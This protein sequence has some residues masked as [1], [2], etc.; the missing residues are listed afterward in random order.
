M[1]LP[2]IIFLTI[3]LALTIGLIYLTF[4]SVQKGPLKIIFTIIILILSLVLATVG[5]GIW[6][7]AE[8]G[9]SVSKDIQKQADNVKIRNEELKPVLFSTQ[10]KKSTFEIGQ[11]ASGN[12][13]NFV[14]SKVETSTAGVFG[15]TNQYCKLYFEVK[16]RWKDDLSLSSFDLQIRD[17]DNQQVY[18]TYGIPDSSDLLKSN[19]AILP[20]QTVSKYMAFD[21]KKEL[22]PY[23]L[24]VDLGTNKISLKEILVYGNDAKIEPIKFNLN[25]AF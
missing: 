16:N 3:L 11:K 9:K 4:K 24:S 2:L 14:V 17:K 19:I 22:S 15:A 25:V 12:N 8:L 13:I 23:T 20:D 6:G 5:F 10:E 18:E 21:C 1:P 7:A